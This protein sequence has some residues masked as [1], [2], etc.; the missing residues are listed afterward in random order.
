MESASF[1]FKGQIEEQK[2]RYGEHLFDRDAD[3]C[4]TCFFLNC[5]A[6][7]RANMARHVAKHEIAGDPVDPLKL[8]PNKVV[9][10]SRREHISA[11]GRDVEPGGRRVTLED[12]RLILQQLMK[13]E[14][15]WP[16]LK[17]VDPIQFPNYANVVKHPM[18][19]GTIQEQLST[20][21]YTTDVGLFL[22]H[23]HL[24]WKN[25]FAY[26]NKGTQIYLY[27][28]ELQR[29]ALDKIREIEGRPKKRKSRRI[30]RE[31]EKDSSDYC[32]VCGEGGRLLICDGDCLQAFHLRCLGM[33]SEPKTE[34]WYCDTCRR[35]QAKAAAAL[36]MPPIKAPN[37]NILPAHAHSLPSNPPNIPWFQAA[38]QNYK[39]ATYR[40]LALS[41][42]L[43]EADKEYYL[44]AKKTPHHLRK[45]DIS[46]KQKQERRKVE[47]SIRE[48]HM[49]YDPFWSIWRP[50]VKQQ[51]IDQLRA[52]NINLEQPLPEPEPEPVVDEEPVLTPSIPMDM[53]LPEEAVLD[54]ENNSDAEF[55]LGPETP[56]VYD[57]ADSEDEELILKPKKTRETRASRKR[58]FTEED[59]VDFDEDD[60]YDPSQWQCKECTY[61]N[62]VSN[63]RCDLCGAAYN[64]QLSLRPRRAAPRRTWVESSD[65]EEDFGRSRRRSTS[66]PSTLDTRTTRSQSKRFDAYEFEEEDDDDDDDD[67]L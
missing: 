52:N 53:E 49:Y 58:R 39:K 41:S 44:A 35:A 46:D 54:V 25:S 7:P 57:F 23:L 48:S 10:A 62:P 19:L 33:N 59:Y 8:D 31:Q 51:F 30:E 2:A 34:K 63:T 27:A 3:G 18:D 26:N 38:L 37:P 47:E 40:R 11:E 6:K 65:D 4:Y 45:G 56:D 12:C 1:G 42:E 17:P 60:L 61:S 66:R 43:I 14:H 16:F 29:E 9:P 24:V 55:E 64:R 20:G 22:E 21:M 50:K 67:L 32:G 15:A 36:E 5:D 13:H 28:E